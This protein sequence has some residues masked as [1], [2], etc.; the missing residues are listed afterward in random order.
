[1]I[2]LLDG[3]EAQN[4]F[5]LAHVFLGG[6]SAS[7]CVPVH[8]AAVALHVISPIRLCLAGQLQRPAISPTTEV[9]SMQPRG[10]DRR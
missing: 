7:L 5:S 1:M 10:V 2:P 4:S 8:D 9:R 3:T 6:I